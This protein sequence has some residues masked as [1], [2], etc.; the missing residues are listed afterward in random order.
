MADILC[1]PQSSSTGGWDY[2]HMY[3]SLVC[4]HTYNCDIFW[5]FLL[6]L[7]KNLATAR[8]TRLGEFFAQWAIVCFEQ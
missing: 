3:V 4:L 6:I 8:V 2:I 7:L 5:P 1:R